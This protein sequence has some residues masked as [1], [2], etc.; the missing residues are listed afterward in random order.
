MLFRSPFV[1]PSA[2]WP[3]LSASLQGKSIAVYAEQGLGDVLQF[4]RYIPLLQRDG[5]TVRCV[6]QQ[7]LISL[8]ESSFD[9]VLCLTP[10]RNFETYYH[11]ALLDLPLRYGT[12]LDNIPAEVPYLKPPP[13]KVARKRP[14]LP[15]E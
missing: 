13:Q 14:S 7:E 11:T 9:D 10:Q 8:I 2:E 4:V 3:G 1:H 6:V 15:A 5:G 12:T